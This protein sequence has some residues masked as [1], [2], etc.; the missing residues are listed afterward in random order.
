MKRLLPLVLMLAVPLGLAADV[1]LA[2]TSATATDTT[3]APAGTTFAPGPGGLVGGITS[4][5]FAIDVGSQAG[6]LFVTVADCCLSG[7][8]F[9]VVVDGVSI[10][11]GDPA[12]AT[13]SSPPAPP[14]TLSAFVSA[15]AHT[16]GIWDITLSYIGFASPFG[17]F[18]GA[19]YSPAGLTVSIDFTP[20]PEPAT[21]FLLGTGLL[22]VGGA[23]RRKLKMKRKAT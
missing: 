7:N 19:V 11:V 9:E 23:A 5:L 12:V 2:P 4:G 14:S 18:V 10:G 16:V 15:G 6:T 17:G 13:G 22:A 3:A 8:V 21:L 20:I 1:I